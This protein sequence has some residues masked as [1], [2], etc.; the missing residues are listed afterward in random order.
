MHACRLADGLGSPAR[1][2]LGNVV[3]VYVCCACK[4]LMQFPIGIARGLC[5]KLIGKVN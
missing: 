4:I 3:C 1:V 2:L 5:E